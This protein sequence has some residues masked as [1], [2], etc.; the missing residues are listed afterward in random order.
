MTLLV[1]VLYMQNCIRQIFLLK[2]VRH[3]EKVNLFCY[4]NVKELCIKFLKHDV[5]FW[6][7]SWRFFKESKEKKTLSARKYYN[8]KYDVSFLTDMIGWKE[9][10]FV[11]FFPDLKLAIL[12]IGLFSPSVIFAFLHL[13]R[14]LPCLEFAHPKFCLKRD[15]L[16]QLKSICPVL[17]LPLFKKGKRSKNKTGEN[18]SL[19][20]I[21]NKPFKN[22]LLL[23]FST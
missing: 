1:S 9:T 16:S 6:R 23:L 11:L 10:I 12:C 20:T 7:F 4:A 14:V 21:N 3:N 15:S 5:Q 17:N 2:F 13:Q 8:N 18:I 22:T 19:Y